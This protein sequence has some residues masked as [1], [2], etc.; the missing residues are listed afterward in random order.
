[1]QRRQFTQTIALL[2]GGVALSSYAGI[3]AVH[4]F[5]KIAASPKYLSREF[6]EAQ[7]G[8]EF[9]VSQHST[10]TVRLKG[11][12]N[13]TRFGAREQFHA[14]FEVSEGIHLAEGNYVLES[15]NSPP[16]SLFLTGV[17]Q[18]TTRQQLIATINQQPLV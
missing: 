10:R 1:M 2:A 3:P 14:I 18:S 8:K 5:I 7:I 17:D 16:M 11:L 13:A 12:E 4:K 15:N 6:F 9:G